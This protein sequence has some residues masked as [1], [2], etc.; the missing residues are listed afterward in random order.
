[1]Q[2]NHNPRVPGAKEIVQLYH[3]VWAE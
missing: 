1:M 2:Q 3:A